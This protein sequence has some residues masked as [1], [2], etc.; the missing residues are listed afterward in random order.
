MRNQLFFSAV[1]MGLFL[2]VGCT[3]DRLARTGTIIGGNVN[4][5]DYAPDFS[6]MGENGKVQTLGSVRGVVTLLVFPNMP[7]WPD[8]QRCKQ[9]VHLADAV[10]KPNTPVVVVSVATP[11]RG[12]K[13]LAA[14]HRCEIK[15]ASQL[16]GLHDRQGRVRALYGVGTSE[17]FFVVDRAGRVGALGSLAD[18][19]VMEEAMRLAVNEHEEYW[20]QLNAPSGG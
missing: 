16:V 10:E 14:L 11:C 3:D 5:G 7:D 18:T 8:C 1:A 19:A 6:F 13:A 4:V 20:R 15:G 9:I 12:D 2:A 17:R